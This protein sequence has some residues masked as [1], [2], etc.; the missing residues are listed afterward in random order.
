M[1][2]IG[3]LVQ[4]RGKQRVQTYQGVLISK[5]RVLGMNTITLRRVFNGIGGVDQTFLVYSS[6]I[7]RIEVVSRCKVRRAKLYYLRYL[8]GK[9]FRLRERFAT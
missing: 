9:I 5:R 1:L 3:I 8:T 4:E 7:K 6:L 2:R